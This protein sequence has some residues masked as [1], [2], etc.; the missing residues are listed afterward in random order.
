MIKLHVTKT[1]RGNLRRV[2]NLPRIATW[3]AHSP[4]CA[5]YSSPS[6]IGKAPGGCTHSRQDVHS[7]RTKAVAPDPAR[8][9]TKSP[10]DQQKRGAARHIEDGPWLHIV[11]QGQTNANCGKQNEKC[12]KISPLWQKTLGQPRHKTTI[13]TT[14]GPPAAPIPKVPL[15]KAPF[16]FKSP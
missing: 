7:I 13:A 1:A 10:T 2:A 14:E 11:P 12:Y 4:W 6:Q 15:T 3:L 8:P 5:T 16:Q 9:S